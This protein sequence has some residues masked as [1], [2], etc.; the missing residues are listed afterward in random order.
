MSEAGETPENQSIESISKTIPRYA[1]INTVLASQE[2]A[3]MLLEN[4]DYSVSKME[5]HITMKKFK[6]RIQKM[7]KKDVYLDPFIEDLLVF[8]PDT[9][10]HDCP[11]VLNGTL[12][13]QDKVRGYTIN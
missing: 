4:L 9:D 1:R 10:L 8:P 5:S 13:L 2:N 11:L 3:I 7:G 6:S 12:V